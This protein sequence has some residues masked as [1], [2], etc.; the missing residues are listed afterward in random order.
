MKFSLLHSDIINTT[1]GTTYTVT[2]ILI[3]F[4]LSDAVYKIM[5][6]CCTVRLTPEQGYSQSIHVMTVSQMSE[7]VD[8]QY[9]LPLST[10]C[11]VYVHIVM[12]HLLLP[13]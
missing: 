4:H 10:D 3:G 2:G 13:A 5:M 9:Q 12:L 6:P 7:H 1:D 11:L 8:I